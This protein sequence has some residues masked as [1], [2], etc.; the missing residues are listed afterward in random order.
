MKKIFKSLERALKNWKGYGD[1][2]WLCKPFHAPTVKSFT[3]DYYAGDGPAYFYVHENGFERNISARGE[4]I[5]EALKNFE[6]KVR[7]NPK[8]HSVRSA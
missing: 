4:T 7:N 3:V 1:A 2:L 5:E 8:V 6:E